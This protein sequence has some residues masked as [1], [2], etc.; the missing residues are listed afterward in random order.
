MES[1]RIHYPFVLSVIHYNTMPPNQNE[2]CQK[3]SNPQ[4]MFLNRRLHSKEDL[5]YDTSIFSPK[6][7]VTG[8]QGNITKILTVFKAQFDIFH[9]TSPLSREIIL[10]SAIW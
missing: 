9:T 7:V 4:N 2:P 10:Q 5:F 1:F 6:I 3:L 8:S